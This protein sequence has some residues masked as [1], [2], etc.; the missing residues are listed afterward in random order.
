MYHH[1]TNNHPVRGGMFIRYHNS[2]VRSL[3]RN[4][5]KKYHKIE[6]SFSTIF[7]Q[8]QGS[9]NN[10]FYALYTVVARDAKICLRTT[11]PHVKM[12]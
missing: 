8:S 9:K 10:I 12:Q 2:R 4:Q 7:S 1:L 3:R 11:L 6:I 5:V